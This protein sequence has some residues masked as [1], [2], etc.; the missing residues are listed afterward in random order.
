MLTDA[1]VC[2]NCGEDITIY[3]RIIWISNAHYNEG[4]ERAKVRDLSGAAE[5]LNKSLK[6]N[7]RNIEARNLLGLVYYELGRVGEALSEW[8]ISAN[9]NPEE[10]AA[11]GYMKELQKD[12]EG[13]ERLNQEV[14]KYNQCLKY[15]QSGNDDL[16]ILQLR[17]AVS[18]NT[19]LVEVYQLL[20]LI[21]LKNEQRSGAKQCFQK[22][23]RL[24]RGNIRTQKYIAS[25]RSRDAA[26][27]DE[28]L[29]EPV[30][31][32]ESISYT[33][34]NDTIIQPSPHAF[35]DSSALPA[36]LNILIGIAV[37][38]AI[39]WFLVVPARIQAIKEEANSSTLSYSDDISSK[40]AQIDNLNKQLETA[41][42]DVQ[43]A[44]A[45]SNASAA[46][47]SSYEQLLTM[48]TEY[49]S[50]SYDSVTIAKALVSIDRTALSSEGQ[51]LYDKLKDNVSSKAVA[52]LFT[53]GKKSYTN[54]NYAD[55]VSTLEEAEAIDNTYGSGELLYYLA[56]SYQEA[57]STDKAK[58]TYQQIISTYP[59]T[60]IATE[61]Q[62]SLTALG[63]TQQ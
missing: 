11:A 30:D 59:G 9:I 41:Q 3:R 60:S 21:L 2:P 18:A 46:V 16:A 19:K 7:K 61:A 31:V 40:D 37:G 24:D 22:A 42:N 4:L 35:R 15:L 36:I 28:K 49:T 47:I 62:N 10:N 26:A 17:K 45:S 39:I 27:S 20:G 6:Y 50:G 23:Y 13:F 44:Q 55:A 8:I 5:S 1:P 14:K 54:K 53:S 34:G 32:G 38:A 25:M 57:G 58:T 48:N 56:M 33:H 12:R 29:N 51:A 63:S 43:T 52:S